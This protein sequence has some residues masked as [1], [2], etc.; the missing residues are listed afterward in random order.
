LEHD[1]ASTIQ[2]AGNGVREAERDADTA[3]PV[4]N[5]RLNAMVNLKICYAHVEMGQEDHG[6]IIS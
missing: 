3:D 6:S 4:A 1:S 2:S 5:M